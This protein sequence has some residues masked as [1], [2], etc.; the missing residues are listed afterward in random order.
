MEEGTKTLNQTKARKENRSTWFD[1]PRWDYR[2]R[3]F[4]TSAH[5]SGHCKRSC[6]WTNVAVCAYNGLSCVYSRFLC[7]VGCLFWFPVVFLYDFFMCVFL[8]HCLLWLHSLLSLW[9]QT[10]S[11]SR[12]P[13]RLFLLIRS[14]ILSLLVSWM[15]LYSENYVFSW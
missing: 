6:F 9:V 8:P 5:I 7:F 2:P 15:F 4:T 3:C 14:H 13:L 12:F 11:C 10:L 1:R